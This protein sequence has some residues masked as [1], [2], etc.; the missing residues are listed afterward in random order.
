VRYELVKVTVAAAMAAGLLLSP[1]LWLTERHY[2]PVPVWDGLPTVPPPWDRGVFG[3]M[4]LLLG[5]ATGVP[6]PRWPLLAFVAVA[7]LW[8]LWDQ[9]RWQPWF[10]QYLFMLAALGFGGC[11]DPVRRESA[12]HTC[13]F[14]L[15]ATYIWSGLQKVNVSFATDMYPWIL[16]P[17]LQK[18]P[19]EWRD[20]VANQGWYAAFME[21]GLGA[22]LLLWPARSVAVPLLVVMHAVLLYCL[23]PWGHD[24][25]SVVW[26]WNGAMMALNVLLFTRTRHVE[27]WHIAWPRRFWLAR[28]TLVLFGVMPLFSFFGWWDAYLS[29]ALYS[30]NT[31]HGYVLLNDRIAEKL[32]EGVREQHLSGNKIDLFNWA[33]AE[34]NVPAYPA[35]RVFRGIGRQLAALDDSPD[36]VVVEIEERPD[37]LTGKRDTSKETVKSR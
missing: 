16:D 9:T 1:R 36:G 31:M 8:S 20:W 30:G 37:W 10:Y 14:I 19:D 32:P 18:L 27:P 5:V 33:M 11:A 6:R 2:P 23:S 21:C 15:A 25:N 26:P 28:C 29:A 35:R 34:M 7:G 3:A 17:V 12:L 24:W 22:G 4:L 13:R